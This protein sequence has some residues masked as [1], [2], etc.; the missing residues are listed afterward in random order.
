MVLLAVLL[1][2]YNAKDSLGKRNSLVSD[3][4]YN[5]VMENKSKLNDIVDCNRDYQFD[6]FGFKTLEKAYLFKING[7]IIERIQYMF[8]RVSLGLHLNDLKS[9]IESS[10]ASTLKVS[11]PAPPVS[12]SLSAPPV[13]VSS[14]SP[15]NNTS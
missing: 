7:K 5:I 9:A 3:E 4:L 12:S 15:P 8:L 2:L 13:S 6:Y 1:I 10:P 14:P 11:A